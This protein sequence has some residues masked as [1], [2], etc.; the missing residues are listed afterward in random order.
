VKE[1]L[2]LLLVFTLLL[3]HGAYGAAH[4]VSTLLHAEQPSSHAATH[5]AMHGSGDGHS[6]VESS[7]H[8]RSGGDALNGHLGHVAYAA[9]L[10][11]FL[12][13]AFVLWLLRGNRMWTKIAVPSLP[14][15][16]IPSV[17]A[18]PSRRPDSLLFFQVLQL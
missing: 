3:C 6:P 18:C 14:E 2:A 8:H 17:L 10:L 9:I 16:I 5:T 13:G 1:A 15:R 4:Q 12:L 7:T 11:V